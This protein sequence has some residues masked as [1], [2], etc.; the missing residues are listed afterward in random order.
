M[1][2]SEMESIAHQLKMPVSSQVTAARESTN[3]PTKTQ[4]HCFFSSLQPV[5][6]VALI[7]F[8]SV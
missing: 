1:C 2:L 7:I 6:F 3:E 5:L 4:D 8:L